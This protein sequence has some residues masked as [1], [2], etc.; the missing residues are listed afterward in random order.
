MS[1]YGP[2]GGGYPGPQDPWQGG[3]NDP[4]GGQP[5]AG[6][7]YGGQ[8]PAGGDPY[9]G[10]PGGGD[11]YGNQPPGGGDPYG[12]QPP[13]GG[14]P[15][16]QPS[17]P[18]G[19]PYGQPS[20]PP[21]GDPYGGQPSGPPA[22]D[23]YGGHPGGPAPY[24]GQPGSPWG[25]PGPGM[26]GP[27]GPYGQG[28]QW[29]PGMPPPQKSNSGLIVGLSIV[30]VVVLLLGVI[31]VFF[32]F[33]GGG[34]GTPSADPSPSASASESPSPSPSPSETPDDE[35][36][37][38]DLAD[39]EEGDCLYDSNS[40][41]TE[42]ELTFVSCDERGEDYYK[43]LARID[44]TTKSKKCEDEAPNYDSAFTSSTDNFVLCVEELL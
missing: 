32:L 38:Y 10:Q 43:V 26:G 14:D 30:G 34:G 12:N 25:A 3:G 27:A 18:Y 4:Y 24:G 28:S 21:A 33:R 6:G 11:P 23:P 7:P 2:P 13:G 8:P 42:A 19:D 17:S 20:G 35:P 1:M 5:G 41:D 16:G 44:G 9:G 22:G 39:A 15:Y 37:K 31:G 29:G 40:S 36:T